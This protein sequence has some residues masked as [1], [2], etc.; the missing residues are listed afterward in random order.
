MGL[1]GQRLD[2]MLYFQALPVYARNLG[3]LLPPLVAAAIGIGIGYLG[4]WV[5][6]PVGGATYGIFGL[7]ERVVWGF[8]F[9]VSIIF[10]DDAWRH[11]RASLSAAWS[12]ARRKAGDILIAVIGFYFLIYVAQLIGGIIGGLLRI[13][14]IDTVLAAIAVWAFIYSIPASAMGGVPAAG[15]FSVSLQ[16]ARRHPLA[17]AI[18]TIVSGAVFYLL[19]LYIPAE[20]GM[21]FGVGFDVARVLLVAFA[22]GYIALILARQ[23]QEIAFRGW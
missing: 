6:E 10:A 12:T 16:T 20:F 17:T 5:S 9:A 7:I 14:Y 15:A 8:G 2:W 1:R 18:I 13:P 3:V 19:T 23:Y 11:N 4:N 21:Y 22:L